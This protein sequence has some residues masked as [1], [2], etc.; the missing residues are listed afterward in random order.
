MKALPIAALIAALLLAA[1]QATAATD[2]ETLRAGREA[3]KI[4]ETCHHFTRPVEKFGPPL[5]GIVGRPVASIPRF[6]YTPVLKGVGGEWTE[7]RIAEFVNDPKAFAPG[8]SMNF[9]GY[10]DMATARAVAA[11]IAR[12][13]SR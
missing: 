2:A 4:C 6:P 13:T 1:T 3:A 11:Y 12:R 8:T 7:E 10:K 5:L 9:D